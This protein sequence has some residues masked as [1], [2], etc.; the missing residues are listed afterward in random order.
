MYWPRKDN[1]FTD[2]HS[3]FPHCDSSNKREGKSEVQVILSETGLPSS[4]T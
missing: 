4:Y 2:A 3:H 1:S